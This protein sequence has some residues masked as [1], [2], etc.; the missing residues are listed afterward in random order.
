MPERYV[1]MPDATETPAPVTM[2]TYAPER[3][4]CASRWMRHSVLRVSCRAAAPSAGLSVASSAGI[5]V[6]SAS[7]AP[8]P[9]PSPLLHSDVDSSSYALSA[10]SVSVSFSAALDAVASV[11]FGASAAGWSAVG[12]AG[13]VLML[14]MDWE[15][16]KKNGGGS[17]CR[18]G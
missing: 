4:T 11:A 15:E 7:S 17:V 1:R 10:A 9:S 18:C 6:S 13:R 2:T 8:L 12:G 16:R 5:A 14:R 3:I